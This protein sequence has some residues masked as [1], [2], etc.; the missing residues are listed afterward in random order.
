MLNAAYA[1]WS[2]TQQSHE[3]AIAP[4]ISHPQNSKTKDPKPQKSYTRRGRDPT[5]SWKW[6]Q[7]PLPIKLGAKAYG[8]DPAAS[9]STAA[10]GIATTDAARKRGGKEFVF[11]REEPE[12]E[13]YL[14]RYE[15]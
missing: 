12:R 9:S 13:G 15:K 11:V 2:N 8:G 4:Q 5:E 14:E 7:D 6:I 3:P 1:Q 10:A